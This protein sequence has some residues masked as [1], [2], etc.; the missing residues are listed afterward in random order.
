VTGAAAV[1]GLLLVRQLPNLP[2]IRQ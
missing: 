1:V 2:L